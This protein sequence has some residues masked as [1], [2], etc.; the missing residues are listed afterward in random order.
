MKKLLAVVLAAF[1]AFSLVSCGKAQ[2]TDDVSV[3]DK[4]GKFT[5]T[6]Q[7]FI[8]DIN[9]FI[10]SAHKD[11][12]YK[13]VKKIGDYTKGEMTIM[14]D[15][16]GVGLDRAV[17]LKIDTNSTGLVS[18]FTLEDRSPSKKIEKAY[19]FYATAVFEIIGGKDS[20]DYIDKFDNW[21]SSDGSKTSVQ[22]RSPEEG[23][24]IVATYSDIL[25]GITL[26]AS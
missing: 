5:C 20:D 16:T 11:G 15:G 13:D 9:S 2:N 25:K 3:I 21:I 7:E 24:W 23:P 18:S 14:K 26:S 10:E 8:D 17:V 1:M 22:F 12:K 6:P 19:I 4:N